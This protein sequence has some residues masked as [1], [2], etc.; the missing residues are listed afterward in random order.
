MF[1]NRPDHGLQLDRQLRPT[2]PRTTIND[3]MRENRWGF[4]LTVAELHSET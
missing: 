3:S 4:L 1:W 2:L